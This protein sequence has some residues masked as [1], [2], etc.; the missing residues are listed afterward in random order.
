MQITPEIISSQFAI[1][2]I[3]KTGIILESSKDLISGPSTRDAVV[4]T[5]YYYDF[6][7]VS[8]S[9]IQW[10]SLSSFVQGHHTYHLLPKS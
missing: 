4:P 9:T 3:G 2:D 1:P 6:D 8:S 10:P 7:G 5:I